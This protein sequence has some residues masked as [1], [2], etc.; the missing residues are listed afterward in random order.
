MTISHIWSLVYALWS[1]KCGAGPR[2]TQVGEP[3]TGY[4][5]V[6]FVVWLSF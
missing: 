2:G 1:P 5:E 6:T 3:G 4:A